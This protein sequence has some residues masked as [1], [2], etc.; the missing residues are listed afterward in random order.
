MAELSGGCQPFAQPLRPL[1]LGGQIPAKSA[2]RIFQQPVLRSQQLCPH[3]VQ[4][5]VVADSPQIAIAAPVH[6]QRLVATAKHVAKKPVPVVVAN[7][8][9]AQKPLHAGHQIAVGVSTTR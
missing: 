5:Y 2:P 6:D 4:M 3:R 7:R 1:G 9:G 8:I